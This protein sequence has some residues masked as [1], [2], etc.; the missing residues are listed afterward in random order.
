MTA[1]PNF[2]YALFAKR[3]RRQAKPGEFDLST[4]RFALSG[5][6][7]VEPA[8]VEDLLD[9]GKPFGLRPG[10]ILPA[11]GMAETTLAVSFSECGAGLVVDEVDADLLAALRRAVPASKRDAGW[12]PWARC[13]RT[14]RPASS[15]RTAMCYRPAAWA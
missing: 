2:A 12:P 11:Y 13:C 5:A 1:A 10:A 8:D 4:L 9:A 7:P 14:S 6:E 15:T 3:L